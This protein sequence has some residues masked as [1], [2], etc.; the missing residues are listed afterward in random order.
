[1]RAGGTLQL[2]EWPEARCLAVVA[3]DLL[4]GAEPALVAV[5]PKRQTFTLLQSPTKTEVVHELE[6]TIPARNVVWR[7]LHKY[8]LDYYNFETEKKTSRGKQPANA[9]EP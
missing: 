4:L 2:R 3:D 8:R 7:E 5:E 6:T 1:M 9:T